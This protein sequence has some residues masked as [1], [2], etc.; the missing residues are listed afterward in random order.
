MPEILEAIRA[1]YQDVEAAVEAL[2]IAQYDAVA[3][4]QEG[5]DRIGRVEIA[6]PEIKIDATPPA[7]LFTSEDDYM[8]ATRK[9]IADK[10]LA[11]DEEDDP[12]D[13][14]RTP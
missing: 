3:R 9:L 1:A 7:P 11:P 6:V 10:A 13:E 2:G 5:A 8:T 12:V 14:G 4:L